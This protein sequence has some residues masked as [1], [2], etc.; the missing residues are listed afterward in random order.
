MLAGSIVV[1]F[2]F[3]EYCIHFS[4]TF[5]EWKS[6]NWR[7]EMQIS[8]WPHLFTF[9]QGRQMKPYL[10]SRGEKVL[11][12]FARGNL[13]FKPDPR[14]DKKP[15]HL[16][17]EIDLICQWWSTSQSHF[18]TLMLF[19]RTLKFTY[20]ECTPD[21]LISQVMCEKC[22]TAEQCWACW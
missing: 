6:R 1:Q 13:H 16:N 17:A 12:T 20:W 11:N 14:P 15:K 5:A 2:W 8:F 3:E 19:G 18:C 10:S 4:A 21:V 22:A 7:T 9:V